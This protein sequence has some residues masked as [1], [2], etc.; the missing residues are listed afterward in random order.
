M[1]IVVVVA[2]VIA[3]PVVLRAAVAVFFP[4]HLLLFL[5][6]GTK[7]PDSS[8]SRLPCFLLRRLIVAGPPRFHVLAPF[9]RPFCSLRLDL[10]PNI[11]RNHALPRLHPCFSA[12]LINRNTMIQLP[13]GVKG[14]GGGEAA[15]AEGGEE[16]QGKAPSSHVRELGARLLTTLDRRAR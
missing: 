5:S 9:L 2:G 15:A 11:N 12:L 1:L 7:M 16:R 6:F 10:A 8:C 4:R 3:V 14:S 13:T